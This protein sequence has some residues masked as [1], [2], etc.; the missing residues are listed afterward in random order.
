MRIPSVVRHLTGTCFRNS[1]RSFALHAT[2]P[3]PPLDR[4]FL[5]RSSTCA[6][7]ASP[8]N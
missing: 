6:R 7:N 1:V 2:A 5:V 3:D 4:L 8:L